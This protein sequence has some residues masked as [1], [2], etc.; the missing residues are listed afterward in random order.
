MIFKGDR[1]FPVAIRLSENERA[2][3]GDAEVQEPLEAV[4]IGGILVRFRP[5]LTNFLELDQSR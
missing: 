5:S 3:L 2:D 4:D 1:R